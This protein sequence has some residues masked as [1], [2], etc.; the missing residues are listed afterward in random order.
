MTY[1]E[2]T[3]ISSL[4]LSAEYNYATPSCTQLSPTLGSGAGGS[5]YN[6]KP[7]SNASSCVDVRYNSTTHINGNPAN[8]NV[9]KTFA[10]A[11]FEHIIKDAKNDNNP[12]Y[13]PNKCNEN[14]NLS[15]N[16]IEKY[17]SDLNLSDCSQTKTLHNLS[18]HLSTDS[19]NAIESF[20]QSEKRK[21]DI[22]NVTFTNIEKLEIISHNSSLDCNDSECNDIPKSVKD[23]VDPKENVANGKDGHHIDLDLE[24][25][26]G[27]GDIMISDYNVSETISRVKTIGKHVTKYSVDYKEHNYSLTKYQKNAE[28]LED[29]LDANSTNNY[30]DIVTRKRKV[31]KDKRIIINNN[32]MSKSDQKCTKSVATNTKIDKVSK[33]KKYSKHKASDIPATVSVEDI[34][35]QVKARKKAHEFTLELTTEA[36]RAI[37]NREVN[38]RPLKG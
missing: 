30:E 31:T 26:V 36:G 3:T 10:S 33:M 17:I 12:S 24:D 4:P 28:N 22:S 9:V 35:D 7:V 13:V 11:K 37:L 18:V 20:D 32:A 25:L 21:I 2:G 23:A 8:N 5:P 34:Q 16:H 19:L 15:N 14:G 6:T 27:N 38:Q 1:N 29:Y